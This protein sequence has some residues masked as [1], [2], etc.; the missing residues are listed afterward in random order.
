MGWIQQIFQTW[1][2]VPSPALP[3]ITSNLQQLEN[4]LTELEQIVMT[5]LQRPDPVPLLRDESIDE[6]RLADLPDAHLGAQ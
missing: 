6:N 1:L 4:R 5:Q 2:G 3:Q